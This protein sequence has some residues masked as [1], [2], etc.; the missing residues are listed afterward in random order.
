VLFVGAT[1]RDLAAEV[2]AQRF[3]ADLYYRLNGFALEIPPLRS[4]AEEIE[5][6]ARGVLATAAARMQCAAPPLSEEA[7]ALLLAHRW[8]GNI[9]ELRN[10]MERALL[11][12]AGGTI[13]P[14]HLPLENLTGRPDPL[15]GALARATAAGEP[16]SE[17]TAEEQAERARIVDALAAAYGN[18]T[19]TA[20]VLGIS[21][22][23]LIT[24]ME[25]YCIP[26]PRKR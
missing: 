26:R 16:P 18:Q 15:H 11:L 7:R 3:R 25:R 5:P 10:M 4:R 1:N 9:R 14:E 19:R 20:E 22:R 8:P 12:S 2:A 13:R 21:R 17:L 6:L 23:W 24:K